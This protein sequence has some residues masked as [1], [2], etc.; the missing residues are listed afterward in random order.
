MKFESK[1]SILILCFISLKAQQDPE[2]SVDTVSNPIV[3]PGDMAIQNTPEHLADISNLQEKSEANIVSDFSPM[4][5]VEPVTSVVVQPNQKQALDQKVLP[6]V[7]KEVKEEAKEEK[8]KQADDEI[9]QMLDTIDIEE[10]GNWLLK[11]VW[12]EQAESVFEK[13][14]S[15]NDSIVKTQMDYFAKRN[16]ADKTLNLFYRTIGYESGELNETIDFLI[17]ESQKERE[18]MGELTIQEREFLEL[19]NEKKKELEQLKSDLKELAQMDETLTATVTQ[20]IEQVNRCRDYEKDAWT[21]FKEIGRSLDDKKARTL[22][23][24]AETD[25]KNIQNISRYLKQDLINYFHNLLTQIEQLSSNIALKIDAF[26]KEGFDLQERSEML[27]RT[28]ELKKQ[29][30]NVEGQQIKQQKIQGKGW[31]A[32]VKNWFKSIFKI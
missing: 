29:N 22:F 5:S 6:E 31:F 17:A 9:G 11:R 3:L 28:D 2:L 1:L 16:E 27:K 30:K 25:F 24:Q 7:K 18:S 21:S 14:I 10:S 19:L 15:L 20:V 4:A 12:W 26:K 32:T 8:E 23:Y 13:I